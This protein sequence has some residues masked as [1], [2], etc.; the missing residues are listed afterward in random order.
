MTGSNGLVGLKLTTLGGVGFLVR[1]E[2]TDELLA[3]PKRM[4]LLIFLAC[5][6]PELHRRDELLALFWPD[7]PDAAARNA[8]SQS[9]HV[10]RRTLGDEVIATRGA[11]EV[12]VA[13]GVIECDAER[14]DSRFESGA[15]EEAVALYTGPFLPAFHVND[16]GGFESWMEL[17]R[18][19]L[20]LRFVE[21]L[22][23][24]GRHAESLQRWTDVVHWRQLLAAQDPLNSTNTAGLVRSMARQGN[25]AAALKLAEEFLRRLAEELGSGPDPEVIAAIEAVRKGSPAPTRQVLRVATAPVGGPEALRRPVARGA[26]AGGLAA[27]VVLAVV[28]ILSVRSGT[29]ATSV[30]LQPNRVIV[31]GFENR[32][33]DSTLAGLGDLAAEGLID[34]LL[35]TEGIEVVDPATGYLAVR[36]IRREDSLAASDSS[37]VPAI[38]QTGR[39]GLVVTGS[40]VRAGDSVVFQAMVS[41]AREDRIVGSVRV[42]SPAALAATSGVLAVRE[43]AGGLIA[44]RLHLAILGSRSLP[45]PRLE[46]YRAF[47]RG[48][49]RFQRKEYVPATTAFLEAA[50][51]DTS[52]VLPVVWARYAAHNGGGTRNPAQV[53]MQLVRDSVG[54]AATRILAERDAVLSPL[55]RH[56]LLRVSSIADTSV[57]IESEAI[58][59]AAALAPGSSFSFELAGRELRALRLEVALAASETVDR[60]RGWAAGWF[61][62]SQQHAMILHLLGRHHEALA[63]AEEWLAADPGN[64]FAHAMV[65]GELAALGRVPEVEPALDQALS[66][67]VQNPFDV[68]VRAMELYAH[69]RPSE[70]ARVYER[71]REWAQAN[72]DGLRLPHRAVLAFMA[73]DWI[74]AE[75]LSRQIL[76]APADQGIGDTDRLQ[77]SVQLITVL[78]RQGRPAEADSISRALL[79]LRELPL[80]SRAVPPFGR[81]SFHA[82][83]GNADS[84][85]FY[86]RETLVPGN[87]GGAYGPWWFS[88]GPAWD[89]IR[90]AAVYRKFIR[91]RGPDP[92]PP[93]PNP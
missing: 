67:G 43:R 31:A 27:V 61:A 89:S 15:L 52:F 56:A 86:L 57:V 11:Q 92:Q 22:S 49:E 66:A 35:R 8:L 78:I 40:V 39:A 72:P 87:F 73:R 26:M 33:G 36:D 44:S 80:R 85:V 6:K 88:H 62:V 91:P 48:L 42:A 5:A 24:L 68:F 3:Q 64:G 75:G 51:A 13:S 58:R 38:A 82:A 55:E 45:P 23:R 79:A 53:A 10:L 19:R 4:A 71:S 18:T 65:I 12:G 37:R 83:S 70:A 46:A 54:R 69:G 9:L 47:M 21:A 14:F 1:T 84:A 28:T 34:G 90:D 60:K 76:A 50:A 81:A 7:L 41:D 20:Q 77:A 74:T 29:D 16:A 25:P 17:E 30:M 59:R 2:A 32:S 63:V 93:T